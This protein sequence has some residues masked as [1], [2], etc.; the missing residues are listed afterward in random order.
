M[1]RFSFRKPKAV[2]IKE[3]L[4]AQAR[5]AEDDAL[6]AEVSGLLKSKALKLEAHQ[7][8]DEAPLAVTMSDSSE[9]SEMQ[10]LRDENARLRAEAQTL[11]DENARLRTKVQR[12][13][14]TIARLTDEIRT[15]ARAAAEVVVA[16]RTC[17]PGSKG[18]AEASGPVR[19]PMG[20]SVRSSLGSS[21]GTSTES[22]MGT[23][24]GVSSLGSSVGTSMGTSMGTTFGVSIGSST[25]SSSEG[26]SVRESG[27]STGSSSIRS[28]VN[29]GVVPKFSRLSVESP[30]EWS[31]TRH[32]RHLHTRGGR[33]SM[34]SVELRDKN[35]RQDMRVRSYSDNG[36]KMI[37]ESLSI[38]SVVCG[39]K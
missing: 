39:V 33:K 36:I 38:G 23:T 37:T 35:A 28:S 32:Q 16:A 20:F 8:E 13:S 18:A 27:S 24:V 6:L 19:L 1:R 2:A 26:S 12:G 31:V 21:V 4:N 17:Q 7:A 10:T 9:Q 11:R 5:W 34:G 3:A 15:L 25:G 29:S 14:E 22:S 30:V